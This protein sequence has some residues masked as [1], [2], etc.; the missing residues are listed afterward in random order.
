M[1]KSFETAYFGLK[2]VL[3]N[4]NVLLMTITVTLF[5][6]TRN[7]FL[8]WLP[9]Y[10][11]VL[12]APVQIIGVFF[13]VKAILTFLMAAP[14]GILADRYGR[15]KTILLGH[16]FSLLTPLFFLFAQTWQQLI[17]GLVLDAIWHLWSPAVYSTIIE[18]LP[19]K[20]RTTGFAIIQMLLL[21]ATS[22]TMLMGGVFTDNFG[23]IEGIRIILIINFVSEVVRLLLRYFFLKETL[24]TKK[25]KDINIVQN[26]SIKKD[27]I[28][29][30][31]NLDKRIW[32]MIATRCLFQMG[33]AM[34]NPFVVLY[35]T[36]SIGFSKTQW[37]LIQMCFFLTFALFS[38]PG[39]MFANRFG[40][41]AAII[42]SGFIA[43]IP[44]F[45]YIFVREFYVILLVNVILGIGAGLGGASFAG[46]A[47]QSMIAKL[48]PTEKR[49]R[50]MGFMNTIAGMTSSITPTI[51]GFLWDI[52]GPST[53]FIS[54]ATLETASVLTFAKYAKEKPNEK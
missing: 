25:Q 8:P 7:L 20:K 38:I 45:S 13:T 27:S 30:K 37:G 21:L 51:G 47:W 49:G 17:P 50:T 15:R 34:A 9:L 19:I 5:H 26:K 53:I 29:S 24:V 52:Y 41:R 33:R 32:A 28:L 48:I 44:L 22:I 16:V 35:I 40:N 1:L 54:A 43:P 14:G 12:G 3:S 10:L 31:L 46:P 18:S 23:L 42:V 4:K 11:D 39:S 36:D 6:F 2:D